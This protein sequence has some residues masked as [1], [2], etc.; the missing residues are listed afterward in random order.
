MEAQVYTIFARAR[1]AEMRKK[2]RKYNITIPS[3]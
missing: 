2:K 3:E 1:S